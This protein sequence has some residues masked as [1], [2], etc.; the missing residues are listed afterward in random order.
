MMKEIKVEK[1][2]A[3]EDNKTKKTKYN[4]EIHFKGYTDKEA[5]GLFDKLEIKE[6]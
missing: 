5:E 2:Y 4:G 6:K 3:Y 1:L